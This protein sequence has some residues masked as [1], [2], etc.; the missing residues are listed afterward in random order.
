V[1]AVMAAARIRRGGHSVARF[2]LRHPISQRV[3]TY[4]KFPYPS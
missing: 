1:G 4:E 3:K 2:L